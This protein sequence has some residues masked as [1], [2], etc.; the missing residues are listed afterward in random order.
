MF[1]ST[2]SRTVFLVNAAGVTSGSGSLIGGS[3]SG[4]NSSDSSVG[5]ELS[6]GTSSGASETSTYTISLGKI[7]KAFSKYT[8]S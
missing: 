1:S 2:N 4:I 3:G 7:S 6:S 5:S 8:K